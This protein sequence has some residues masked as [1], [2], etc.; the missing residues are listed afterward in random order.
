MGFAMGLVVANLRRFGFGGPTTAPSVPVVAPKIAVHRHLQRRW[1]AITR[2]FQTLRDA[3]GRR[4]VGGRY[5]SMREPLAS[6]REE[7]G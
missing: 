5:L 1:P 4:R 2:S 7:I 6:L 3:V